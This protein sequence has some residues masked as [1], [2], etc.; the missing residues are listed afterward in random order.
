MNY[1]PVVDEGACAGHGDCVEVAPDVFILSDV[2]TVIDTGPRDLMV[3]AA[4]A[5]PAAA[6][7]V[8]DEDSGVPVY[9]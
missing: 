3:K 7:T 1:L 2:A 5:C 4:E 8:I 6:I 9:P